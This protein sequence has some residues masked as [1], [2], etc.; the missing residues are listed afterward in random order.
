MIVLG[1]SF[2]WMY[3]NF[4]LAGL[5]GG[6]GVRIEWVGYDRE[7]VISEWWIWMYVLCC[8]CM[9]FELHVDIVL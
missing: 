5:R 7:P 8:L 3:R 9:K 1:M 6:C 4:G 2:D